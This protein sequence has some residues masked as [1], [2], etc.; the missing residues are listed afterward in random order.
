VWRT[1]LL[2][3]KTTVMSLKLRYVNDESLRKLCQLVSKEELEEIKLLVPEMI[4]VMKNSGGIALAANQVG[5]TKRF[6]IMS[7][8]AGVELFINPKI[9]QSSNLRSFDESCLSIPGVSQKTKRFHSITVRYLDINFEEQTRDFL[10]INAIA[11]Q[12]EIDHLDGKLYIDNLPTPQKMLLLYK[13]KQF[14]K[15]RNSCY[16]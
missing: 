15:R 13:H 10:G 5:I 2:C 7:T 3:G 9:L 1:Q 4:A 12:H 11:V 14:I 6:F 16:S 8:D